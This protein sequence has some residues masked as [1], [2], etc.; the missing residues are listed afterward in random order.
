[1]DLPLDA[2]KTAAIE[3]ALD[4]AASDIHAA[5]AANDQCGCALATWA[6]AFLGKL[7]M[8]DAAILQNCPCGVAWTGA[9]GMAKRQMWLAWATNELN[10]IRLGNYELCAGETGVNFPA[11]A[12][13]ERN[14]TEF[15]EAEII[16]H[17][18]QRNP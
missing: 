12:D 10:N 2:A 1:L 11:I 5:M 9:E 3:L 15:S 14:L 17:A 18:Q 4:I 7:N 16:L 8:I 6:T 13:A